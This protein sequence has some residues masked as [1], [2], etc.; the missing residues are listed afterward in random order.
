MR[1]ISEGYLR[2]GPK[3]EK[4]QDSGENCIIKSCMFCTLHQ[5]SFR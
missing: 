4:E 3:R 1:N 2:I 5:V